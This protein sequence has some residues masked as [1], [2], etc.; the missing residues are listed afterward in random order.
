[1]LDSTNV[2][3][4][5]RTTSESEVGEGIMRKVLEAKVGG[6]GAG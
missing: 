3:S 4:P 6:G 5:G 1:M 2:L